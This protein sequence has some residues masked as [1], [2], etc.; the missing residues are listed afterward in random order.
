VDVLFWLMVGN[1]GALAM[2]ANG[3]HRR[4][5][6]LDQ[7]FITMVLGALVGFRNPASVRTGTVVPLV[8]GTLVCGQAR[9]RLVSWAERGRLSNGREAKRTG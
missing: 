3:T 8:V 4:L 6:A 7:G 2:E 5:C 9:G 1:L